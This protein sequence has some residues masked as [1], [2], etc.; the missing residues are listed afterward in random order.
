MHETR[1]LS[2]WLG[3]ALIVASV[4]R[5]APNDQCQGCHGERTVPVTLCAT[6]HEDVVGEYLASEHGRSAAA[7]V[8]AVPLCMTC[9]DHPITRQRVG[10]DPLKAKLEQEK[11]CLSCHRDD[12]AVRERMTPSTGFIA[13]YEGSV[14][15][16]ALL[17]GNLRAANCVDCHGAHTVRHGADAES[18]VNRAHL[19]ATC[20]RCHEEIAAAYGASVHA[21]AVR[22]GSLEAPVCTSCHGE[23][24]ILRRGDPSSP[25]ASRNVSAMVCAPC[26]SSIRLLEKYGLATQRPESYAESYHGLALRGGS[27]EAANCASCHGAHRIL[28]SNN[29]ASSI[30]RANL[31]ATCGQC[32]PG[33]NEKFAIGAVHVVMSRAGE[34]V[35]YWI[36]ALYTLAIALTVGGMLAHNTLDFVRT[37]RRRFLIRRGRILEE[38]AGP[39]LY[40][41]MT[42]GERIQHGALVLSFTVLVVTGFM[43]R[44]PDAFWVAWIRSLGVGVFEIRSLL[45]RLA[46]VVLLVTIVAHV[47][48]VTLTAHGR[49]LIRDLLPA[50]RDLEEMIGAL[51]YSLGLSPQR[52]LFGRF[53]YIEKSEYWAVAWGSG[54]MIL[55]GVAMWFENSSIRILTKLGWDVS[56][57]IHFYEAW[58]AVLAILVWH[59]YHV[60]FRPTVYPMNMAWIT[61]TLTEAEMQEGHPLVLE[62]I[63]EARRAAEARLEAIRRVRTMKAPR[64]AAP[65]PGAGTE[66]AGEVKAGAVSGSRDF[67]PP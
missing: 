22:R 44:Y 25:V 64:P 47:G 28:P 9:H 48:Q 18:R 3:I 66:R 65:P 38:P 21:E 61:G 46:G 51:R 16:A 53:S 4:P 20:A 24:R 49:P 67:P 27:V 42:L 12:P 62:E 45:H 36:A 50:R 17:G 7:G 19:P 55:T 15:G 60:V 23:H 41:R 1:S 29:P 58:L 13:A 6:C 14:H 31:A 54:V 52:P 37:S 10:G 40:P 34:P 39:T 57:T 59:F 32:H 63:G 8:R 2:V 33:A 35:L 56:R 30:H 26:H 11:L 5:A 43:L